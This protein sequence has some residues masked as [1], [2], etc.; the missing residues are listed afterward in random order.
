MSLVNAAI[1]L[2]SRMVILRIRNLIVFCIVLLREEAYGKYLEVRFRI[3][4]NLLTK[5]YLGHA[6]KIIAIILPNTS[7]N[8]YI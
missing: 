6:R 5:L 3:N 1:N 8:W 7:V 2:Q 4:Y